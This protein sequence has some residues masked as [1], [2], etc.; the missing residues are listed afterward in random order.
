M[1]RRAHGTFRNAS[2]PAATAAK[3]GAAD[4]RI[5]KL[6]G[7]HMVRVSSGHNL[8]KEH[9]PYIHVSK[10][11]EHR[12]SRI[13]I[14]HG[15]DDPLKVAAAARQRRDEAGVKKLRKN[16]VV[17]LE[18]MVT[19]RPHS[20]HDE[21][22]FF[23]QSLAWVARHFGGLA[24]VLTAVVHNDESAPHI[25]VLVMPV[26]GSSMAGSALVGG[27]GRLR[28]LRSSFESEVCAFHGLSMP[29]G[30]LRGD[31]KH[32][33]SDAVLSRIDADDDPVRLSGVW[34]SVQDLIRR[35][36]RPFLRDLGIDQEQFR[37]PKRLRTSTQ[38]FTS[39]GKGPQYRREGD[40]A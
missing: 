38:I 8:R 28:A 9:C 15:S 20:C 6:H 39:K 32:K 21:A 5:N 2:T 14:L 23:R 13:E 26:V 19:L 3:S 31:Q 30:A 29:A 7:A 25:H 10:V 35:D 33:A 11:L 27:P 12:S 34:L 24:N 16:Q 40:A 37:P 17:A 22:A 1:Q 4:L 18:I 36:P